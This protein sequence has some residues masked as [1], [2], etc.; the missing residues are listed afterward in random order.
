M[1]GSARHSWGVKCSSGDDRHLA[2]RIFSLGKNVMYTNLATGST[3]APQ[4]YCRFIAQQTRWSKSYWRELF[5]QLKWSHHNWYMMRE[6]VYGLLFPALIVVT[7]MTAIHTRTWWS[8]AAIGAATFTIPFVKTLYVFFA[9][10]SDFK[11]FSNV[12]YPVMYFTTL[13]PI[14]LVA[15][16]S[17][18]DSNGGTS[19]RKNVVNSVKPVFP[20]LI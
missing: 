8:L 19:T 16:F 5:L 18:N 17:I 2:N 3:E 13:L 1:N 15:L 7:L 9:F 11:L 14:K 6:M 4:S 12:F 10:K 20:I